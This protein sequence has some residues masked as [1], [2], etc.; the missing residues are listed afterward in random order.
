MSYPQDV[1]SYPL[2]CHTHLDQETS[3]LISS[4]E[5]ILVTDLPSGSTL[6]LECESCS[7]ETC[8]TPAPVVE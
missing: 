8:T 2:S 7:Q 6:V 4:G 5:R 3:S 1:L